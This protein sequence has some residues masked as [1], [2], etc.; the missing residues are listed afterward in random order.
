[1]NLDDLK[2]VYIFV[3]RNGEMLEPENVSKYS[4]KNLIEDN[5]NDMTDMEW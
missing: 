4:W 1:M 2:Q 3:S 5:D